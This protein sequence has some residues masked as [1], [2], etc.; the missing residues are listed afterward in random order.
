MRRR[1]WVRIGSLLAVV[2][3]AA[4]TWTLPAAAWPAD[5]YSDSAAQT[6]RT[7]RADTGESLLVFTVSF[8]SVVGQR[9][10][11]SGE[12]NAHQ[13]T[14]TTDELLMAVVSVAC[15]NGTA[16]GYGGVENTLRGGTTQF[17][18]QFV[19]VAAATGS[20][21]CNLVA[22]AGR[23]R[24]VGTDAASNVWYV[25]SGSALRVSVPTTDWS[26]SEKSEAVSLLR[27]AGQYW[28][29]VVG[30]QSVARGTAVAVIAQQKVTSCTTVGGSSD[31]TTGDVDLCAGHVDTTGSRVR[32]DVFARQRNVDDTG[33]CMPA[34]KI[35]TQSRL[36]DRN[37]HHGQFHVTGAFTTSTAV[38]CGTVVHYYGTTTIESGSDAV[39]HAPSAQVTIVNP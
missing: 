31:G 17:R 7:V 4:A 14:T 12:V 29:P 34:V 8:A 3:L 24:P 6:T 28:T 1:G 33:Y 2:A 16:G 5:A 25:E 10:L 15:T 19:H 26:E 38:G 30:K 35:G 27:T 37:V 11:V 21:T 22:K 36:I 13:P 9:R 23:P 32:L 39:V 18:L 20:T